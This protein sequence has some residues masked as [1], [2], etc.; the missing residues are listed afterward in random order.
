MNFKNPLYG[1]PSFGHIEHRDN[2]L[3]A[4]Q[5]LNRINHQQLAGGFISTDI[6]VLANQ[7]LNNLTHLRRTVIF[8]LKER[9][10]HLLFIFN[11]CKRLASR[12]RGNR[13]SFYIFRLP[14]TA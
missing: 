1:L 11:H 5:I 7:G 13:A 2:P 4:H 14:I 9:L 3:N 12:Y 8:K 6:A 10:N